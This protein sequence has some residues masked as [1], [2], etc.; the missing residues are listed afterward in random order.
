LT[1]LAALERLETPPGIVLGLGQNG[2]ATVRALG[3]QGV[4][5]IGIDADLEQAT[6]RSRY[7]LPVRCHGFKAGNGALLDTLL[8][9]GR[10]LPRRGMLFPSGDLNL[11]LVSEQREALAPYFHFALPDREAVRLVLDK[12][13]FYAFALQTGF[14]IPPTRFLDGHDAAAVARDMTYPVLLKPYLRTAAWRQTHHVK[15]YEARSPEDY[16]RLVETLAAWDAELIVQECV[17]GPDSALQFSLTYLDRQLEPL[18]MFTGRKLR[19]FPPRFGTS[20]FAESRWD[21]EVADVSLGVLRALR[22]RG[23]GS[24]EF[25]RDPRDG[26]LKIIEVTGRTWYPHGLATRC[27]VNLPYLAYCDLLGLPV[28]RPRSFEDGVKWVDEDRD[29]RSGLLQ[30]RRGELSVSAWLGSYRGR[31]TYAIGAVDDPAPLLAFLGRLGR[32]AVRRARPRPDRGRPRAAAEE[33]VP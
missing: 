29:L 22:Y 20:S 7:C 3:R 12:R 19:Q 31:R 13:A 1:P 17:P 28:E 6:A 18:G 10:Q 16:L 30:W 32:A 24:V 11:A 4:P 27:G 23:Y 9:L 21:P 33:R 26:Q 25:K 2:L 8:D 14:P 15:L 5:V